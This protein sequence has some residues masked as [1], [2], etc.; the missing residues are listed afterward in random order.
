MK[1]Q[2]DSSWTYGVIARI[3]EEIYN[4]NMTVLDFASLIGI[5]RKTLNLSPKASRNINSYYL[6]K[7]AKTLNISVDYI[8]GLSDNKSINE[9][10]NE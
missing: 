6:Y 2:T 4:Q 3:Q 7:I 5:D 8:L 9:V 10:V 1:Q